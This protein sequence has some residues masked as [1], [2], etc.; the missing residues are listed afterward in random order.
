VARPIFLEIVNRSGSQ[1]GSVV[2]IAM[3][4]RSP[5]AKN[6]FLLMFAEKNGV[7]DAKDVTLLTEAV[8][9]LGLYRDELIVCH[10]RGREKSPRRIQP[11]RCTRCAEWQDGGIPSGLTEA[12]LQRMLGHG[13]GMFALEVGP[14]GI[15]P[16]A[17]RGMM[18]C[19][20]GAGMIPMMG[21]GI[22]GDPLSAMAELSAMSMVG[23]ESCGDRSIIRM[24]GRRDTFD[25]NL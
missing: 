12:L 14:A 7:T 24:P 11:Q 13:E 3:Q 1:V 15:N 9:S 10:H 22:N 18:G 5:G 6:L 19:C 2:K 21:H 16:G 17:F 4:L 25:F 8:C 20:D 23:R